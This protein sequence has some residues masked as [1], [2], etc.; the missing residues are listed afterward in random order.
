V[1]KITVS[2]AGGLGNQLF[3]YAFALSLIEQFKVTLELEAGPALK[4]SE[5]LTEILAYELDSRIEINNKF[6]SGIGTKQITQILRS[7][8]STTKVFKNGIFTPLIILFSTISL[9]L[10]NRKITIPIVAKGTG[11]F[12]S[13]HATKY[14]NYFVGFFQSSKW[15]DFP[16]TKKILKELKLVNES[17]EINNYKN[18]SKVEEPLIVHIRLGDYLNNPKFGIPSPQYYLCGIRKLWGSGKFKKIWVFTNDQPAAEKIFPAEFLEYTRWIPEIQGSASKTLE[19]MRFGKGYIIANSTFSW[20]GARLSYEEE[21]DVIVP[22]PW[23][24]QA[25]VPIDLIPSNWEELS[26]GY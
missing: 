9:S 18:L 2:L 17:N 5:G 20:W 19:V 16:N 26:A 13:N 4:D 22:K 7:L 12:N 25:E 6:K 3:Q 11:Y 21:P 10:I 23:F 15:H 1:K 14:G 8:S 24:A